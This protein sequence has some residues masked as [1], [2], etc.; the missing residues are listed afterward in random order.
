MREYALHK[1]M[2]M[3]VNRFMY[4]KEWKKDNNGHIIR[5]GNGQKLYDSKNLEK[6]IL[7]AMQYFS[8]RIVHSDEISNEEISYIVKKVNFDSDFEV[9]ELYNILTEKLTNQQYIFRIKR[10]KYLKNTPDSLV[11]VASPLMKELGKYLY[12]DTIHVNTKEVKLFMD[13]GNET[14]SASTTEGNDEIPEPDVIVS[15]NPALMEKSLALE[16]TKKEEKETVQPKPKLKSKPKP[17]QERMPDME[18]CASDPQLDIIRK[19]WED[20]QERNAWIL[21]NVSSESKKYG[22]NNIGKYPAN[23]VGRA[24]GVDQGTVLF[25]L[26]KTILNNIK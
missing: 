7:F 23:I 21:K 17:R 20:K 16:E 13:V 11:L 1:K 18:L 8:L 22:Y 12:M 3:D 15:E 25:Y 10:I 2:V 19:I 26:R 9:P 24:V 14:L 5:N 4:V 6:I